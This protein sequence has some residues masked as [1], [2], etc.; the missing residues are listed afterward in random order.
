MSIAIYFTLLLL[1]SCVNKKEESD[2]L[3]KKA[4]T[5]Y[6]NF[7]IDT[8]KRIDSALSLVDSAIILDDE[9]FQAYLNKVTYLAE[10]RDLEGLLINNL[11]MIELK[12]DQPYW[13]VQRGAFFDL[14]GLATQANKL[15]DE[16][17]KQYDEIFK[18]DT[19]LK[20]DLNFRLEYITALQ[21][22][23]DTLKVKNEYSILKKKFPD[24]EILKM[25]DS[26]GFQSKDAVFD[27]W[28]KQD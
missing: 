1:F 10:K 15:Y 19:L 7:D 8:E 23:G 18:E 5:V 11:K 16:G 20:N 3:V 22:K 6:L 27:I 21:L 26:V 2:K 12:P 17:I 14:K 9:N 13:K 24:N 25:Y 28:Y 4:S